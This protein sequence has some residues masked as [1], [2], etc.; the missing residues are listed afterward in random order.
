[1]LICAQYGT[2]PTLV[3]TQD[4]HFLVVNNKIGRSV[5]W[6]LKG[7]INGFFLEGV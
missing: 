5:G 1:M 6:G 7:G 3:E 4:Q 2:N